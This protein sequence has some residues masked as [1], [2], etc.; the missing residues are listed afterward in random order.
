MLQRL[1]DWMMDKAAHRH[2][3]WWLTVVSFIE[4]SIFPL[5]PDIMLIP[6]ILATPRRWL[7]LSLVCTATS[8][9]GG[10][11]GYAIGYYAMDSVGMAVLG[12]L[13]LVDKFQA[14]KPLVDEYGVWVILVKGMTPIPY[15]LVTISAGAFKFD[16]LQFTVASVISRAMRFLIVGA[17]LWKFGP[18][19]REFVERRLKLVTTAFVI[20]LIGGFFAVKLL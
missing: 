12:A 13:H 6:M 15:K 5:P 1:Y 3:I 16:L 20:A 14:L 17:L 10:F 2:A 11:V 19:I 4:S 18:P 9:A 7:V 8:V